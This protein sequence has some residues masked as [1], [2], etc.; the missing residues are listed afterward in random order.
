MLAADCSRTRL[1]TYTTWA[2]DGERQAKRKNKSI[3][4][5]RVLEAKHTGHLGHNLGPVDEEEKGA[6]LV[7]DRPGNHRLAGAGGPIQQNACGTN[8]TLIVQPR[9]PQPQIVLQANF[10]QFPGNS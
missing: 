7:G 9:S 8:Q 1:Q 4:R 6:R 3:V 5:A 2:H 10:I